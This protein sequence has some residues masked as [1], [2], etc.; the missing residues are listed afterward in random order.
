MS[1]VVCETNRKRRT[2]GGREHRKLSGTKLEKQKQGFSESEQDAGVVE[3][4]RYINRTVE[5]G[6]MSRETK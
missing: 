2:G 3:R 1:V 5:R 4:E 6:K